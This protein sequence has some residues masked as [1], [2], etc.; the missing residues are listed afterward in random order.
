MVALSDVDSILPV[1]D[2]DYIAPGVSHCRVILD[3]EVFESVEEAALHLS[4]LLGPH[5]GIDEPLSSS[6]CVEEELYRI[7]SISVTVIDE[8]PRRSSH[9]SR[10]EEAEGSSS[11][12]PQD[13]LPANRLLANI[14]GHLSNIEGR[15]SGASS[16]HYVSAIVHLEVLVCVFSRDVACSQELVHNLDL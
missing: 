3:S 10:L 5:S 12:S 14:G 7:Q 13:S 1:P 16:R 6:H 15:A 9:V 8:T 2:L 11:V 4:A